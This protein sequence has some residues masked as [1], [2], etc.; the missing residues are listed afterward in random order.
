MAMKPAMIV[1]VLCVVASVLATLHRVTCEQRME[2]T[3]RCDVAFGVPII[4]LLAVAVGVSGLVVLA[5]S[6]NKNN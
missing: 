6:D 1:I 2:S 5:L 4:V 3:S